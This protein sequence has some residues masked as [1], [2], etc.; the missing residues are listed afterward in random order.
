MQIIY[1]RYYDVLAMTSTHDACDHL[2][3]VKLKSFSKY[4][5]EVPY[6]D[7]LMRSL[8]CFEKKNIVLISY[9]RYSPKNLN[10]TSCF[11]IL[12]KGWFHEPPCIRPRAHIFEITVGLRLFTSVFMNV[13]P[14]FNRDRRRISC[15]QERNYITFIF[16]RRPHLL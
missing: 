4:W 8:I 1:K 5:N 12:C 14:Y 3:L 2:Q 13:L 10:R 7:F 9:N 6:L 15:N 16:Y 11:E